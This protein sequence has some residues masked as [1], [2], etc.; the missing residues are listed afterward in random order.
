MPDPVRIA[1]VGCGGM[2]HRHLAGLAEYSRVKPGSI[3]LTAVCDR[4]DANAEMLA[5]QAHS[6]L[7]R[8]PTIFHDVSELG[9]PSLGLQAADCVTDVGS[10]HL[11]AKQLLRLGLHTQCEKPLGLTIR[12][13]REIIAAREEAGV[14]LSVAEN[15][16]RDPMNRLVRALIGDGAI[17]QP[18]FIHEES[19]GGRDGIIIT[20]WRHMR[21][22]GTVTLDT[23]V[24]PADILE[25]YFGPVQEV[26]GSVRLFEEIRRKRNVAGPGGFYERWGGDYPEQIEPD[27]ED[28]MFG[29]LRFENG[30]VGQW[31][32]HHA[33]HGLAVRRRE[34]Y[35]TRGSITAPGDRNGL[36]A[37]LILDD[38]TDVSDE[39]ILDHAPSYRLNPLA[40]ELFGGERPWRYD[41]DFAAIDRKLIALEYDELARCVCEGARPEVGGTTALRSLALVYALFE[42]DRVGRSVTLDEVMNSSVDLY[43]RDLDEQLGLVAG[44]RQGASGSAD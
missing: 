32:D 43:Q 30:A 37:R 34:V 23:G 18:Q 10:H 20:P 19:V 39:R 4:N 24:H 22:T 36:P 40:A 31:T 25:Y 13:A 33:G 35:G 27:G 14:T 16:R 11:V 6:L 9:S 15:F 42:S 12:A 38:G 21:R 28:A 2:G 29:L 44:P 8:T 5:D 26:S 3:E 17:G 1:I 41:L 7:G